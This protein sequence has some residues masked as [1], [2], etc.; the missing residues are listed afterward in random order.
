MSVSER[1]D[2]RRLMRQIRSRHPGLREALR[3]DARVTA[4]YRGE[5]HE[6]RSRADAALQILRLMW[7][8]DAFLAQALYRSKA[9]LQALDVPVLPRL[10]HRLAMATAQVSIGDPVIVHP[11][12]CIVHGQVVI[13]GI[14]EIHSGAVIGPFVTIGRRGGDLV[15][16]T[17]G[18]GVSISTGAK[19]LGRLRVGARARIGA[20]AVVIDDVA[21]GT[22]AVGVP[23]RP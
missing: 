15:G 18:G 16:P 19:I 14:T 9:R 7:T 12:V 2:G 21:E 11:G 10:A 4:A 3:A 5:R 1:A 8:S 20:N 13:D 17:V 22:T 23:A 6:F